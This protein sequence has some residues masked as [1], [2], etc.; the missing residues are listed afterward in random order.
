[1]ATG[2]A[3]AIL[4]GMKTIT[5]DQ[6]AAHVLESDR[7]VVV[8]FTA[9]WC[10]PCRV[11]TPVLEE[12]AAE[13]ED[14]RFVQLDVDANQTTAARYGVMSMPTFM[15]FDNGVYKA[16]WEVPLN[17]PKGKYRFVIHANRYGL[18][19]SAFTVKPSRALT[20]TQLNSRAGT[21]AVE[22][23]YPQ[24]TQHEAVCDPAGDL[25]AD[26]TARPELA[27]PGS[28][29]FLVN[30]KATTVQAFVV[31]APAGAAVELKP[32]A[33]RDKYGN[34]NGNALAP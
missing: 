19:S 23:H 3:L 12:L 26:L 15:V 22:L 16:E 33:V 10:A 8:D 5:D 4:G 34:T 31:A 7:P 11:M 25:T 18:T 24:A 17:A 20:V 30:G 9:A 21:V 6:F 14:L 32:G 1:M 2:F 27:A 13:R 28:A 29:T